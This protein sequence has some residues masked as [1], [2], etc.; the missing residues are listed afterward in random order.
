MEGRAENRFVFVRQKGRDLS[1]PKR[2]II[3]PT[4]AGLKQSIARVLGFPRSSP[5]VL[6]FTESN[7]VI[8]AIEDIK[9][10]MTIWASTLK[11]LSGGPSAQ[12]E[13]LS[14][15]P[16]K[17]SGTVPNMKMES[18]DS[19]HEVVSPSKTEEQHREQKKQESSS[20]DSLTEPLPHVIQS[21]RSS[22]SN[23]ATFL[24][25][26]PQIEK[27]LQC[28]I[29][30]EVLK[31]LGTHKN[32]FETLKTSINNL[33]EDSIQFDEG[34][35]AEM[36]HLY[37][38]HNVILG[39][40]KSGKS[41][42]LNH[43]A[44]E[45]YKAMMANGQYKKVLLFFVDFGACDT[46]K[47]WKNF[48]SLIISRLID[49][50]AAQWPLLKEVMH[51]GSRK[52]QMQESLTEFLMQ[53]LDFSG[54]LRPIGSGWLQKDFFFRI[55][56]RIAEIGEQLAEA[57]N[58]GVDMALFLRLISNLP[59]DVAKAFGFSTVY[60]VFDHMDLADVDIGPEEP[61]SSR[62]AF[63]SRNLIEY[64][65]IMVNTGMFSVS[66]KEESC[67]VSMLDALTDDGCDLRFVAKLDSTVG[68]LETPS[69]PFA[70]EVMAIE[71]D[72]KPRL[73]VEHC[74][75]CPGYLHL[76][77]QIS[78]VTEEYRNLRDDDGLRVEREK[79]RLAILVRLR[80]LA[81]LVMRFQESERAAPRKLKG[82]IAD[83][84]VI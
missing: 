42:V 4:L 83:F 48:Y 15:P 73:T 82:R 22:T 68:L 29:Y 79:R 54:E 59:I 56:G 71:E 67:F 21:T 25:E 44:R 77:D 39:P 75:G 72:F 11:K 63:E 2:M 70:F 61:F 65:K 8:V 57:V 10:G 64:L 24:A 18:S 17:L 38:I 3:E 33:I 50:L 51:E 81:P 62:S 60:F 41:T 30:S 55:G 7:Q 28:S 26:A 6:L 16:T 31:L 80:V 66:C 69:S 45:L 20:D 58:D 37:S 36:S 52:L 46:I 34:I 43:L 49:S 47:N 9:P 84:T 5:G 76:W 23:A 19:S 13:S 35:E 78:K 27:D 14:I 1:Q 40:S 32:T 12:P 74:S 53:F